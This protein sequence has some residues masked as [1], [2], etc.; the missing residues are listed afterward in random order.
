MNRD[1]T[2]LSV[3]EKFGIIPGKKALHKIIYFTNL[4]TD[5]FVYRWNNYGPYSEEVQQFYEDASLDN[6]IQ[7]RE[8]ALGGS[9]TQY[10]MS[11]HQRGK[12]MLEELANNKNIDFDRINPSI[13]FAL[14][15]LH[16]MT[17]RQ[18][19]ILAS[20]HYITTYDPSLDDD[21]ILQ[22]INE[23]KPESNFTLQ[24]VED[25]LTTLHNNHLIPNQ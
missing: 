8:V 11:L 4:Q 25:S 10:N 19:E 2:L 22:I 12:K 24:E 5:D 13:D 9:A 21:R 3:I 7:V 18:M 1:Y 23:L 16:K 20:V 15:L 17:P 6:V 14:K